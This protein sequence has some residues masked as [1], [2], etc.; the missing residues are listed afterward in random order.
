MPT[1]RVKQETP[2]REVLGQ[3]DIGLGMP[4]NAWSAVPSAITDASMDRPSWARQTALD[5]ATPKARPGYVQRWVR[6]AQADGRPDVANKSDALMT[7]W[8][9]RRE[10]T[11]EAADG[12][13]PI[14]DPGDGRGG[15]IIF[16]EQLLLCE[17]PT[18][19]H[20]RYTQKLKA[21]QDQIN[22]AIYTDTK[23]A[24]GMPE[25]YATLDYDTGRDSSGLI[26]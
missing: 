10:S 2:E 19:M 3:I 13:M 7:G 21:E 26:D 24:N 23:R 6:I 12:M 18:E 14:Y 4:D 1:P 25:K 22:R 8:R 15:V 9:P 20:D 16:K 11:L 5:A 17:M